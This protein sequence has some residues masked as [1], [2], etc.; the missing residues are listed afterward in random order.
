MSSAAPTLL[1]QWGWHIRCKLLRSLYWRF[2][3]GV[4]DPDAFRQLRI[5]NLY[6]IKV[7]LNFVTLGYYALVYL[8]GRHC[9]S[10]FDAL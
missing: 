1:L 4:S 6:P 9:E 3:G 5:S 8:F 2:R 7:A 10:M